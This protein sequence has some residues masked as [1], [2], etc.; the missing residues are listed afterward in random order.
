MLEN[1]WFSWVKPGLVGPLRVLH[2]LKYI[3]L[4]PLAPN[5]GI[6]C[7][8]NLKVLKMKDE[9]CS[10]YNISC[11]WDKNG[12]WLGLT[13]VVGVRLAGHKMRDSRRSEHLEVMVAR[14]Q[15][16]KCKYSHLLRGQCMTCLGQQKK[17]LELMPGTVTDGPCTSQGNAREM[18]EIKVGWQGG[19]QTV[20][21]A[22]TAIIRRRCFAELNVT[23]AESFCISLTVITE[24]RTSV[25][26]VFPTLV[27][28]SPP[29][30]L[31]SPLL[32]PFTPRVIDMIWVLASVIF[33]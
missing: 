2:S 14:G 33:F 27:F 11:L 6:N 1:A 5:I 28:F 20:R 30:T 24:N 16:S 25:S 9:F 13:G 26:F 17:S 15:S 7:N 12:A 19:R 31:F 8:E 23:P 10:S 22:D 3:L 32:P 29:T 21:P 18:V 4:P